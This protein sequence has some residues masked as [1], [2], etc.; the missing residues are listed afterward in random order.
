MGS[1]ASI[2]CAALFPFQNDSYVIQAFDEMSVY[3]MSDKIYISEDKM[4][5]NKMS[6]DSSLSEADGIISRHKAHIV[7][8][9]IHFSQI[10]MEDGHLMK[11]LYIHILLA[12]PK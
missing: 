12:V 3:Q 8:P 1:L 11:C 4:S 10:A 5:L 6:L 2:Y 9:S 7:L